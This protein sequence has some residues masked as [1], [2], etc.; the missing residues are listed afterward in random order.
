MQNVDAYDE[1]IDLGSAIAETR[2][3]GGQER[4]L[5]QSPKAALGILDD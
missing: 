3:L 5:D 4:D 2:G 1:L